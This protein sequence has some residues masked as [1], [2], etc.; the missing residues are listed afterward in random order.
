MKKILFSAVLIVIGQSATAQWTTSGTSIYNT[1]TGNVGI[2]TTTPVT[3]L[4]ISTAST[5]DG[6]RIYQTGTTA[7]AVGLF[8]NSLNAHN[9]ALFS[10]GSGNFEGAGHFGLFDY[11]AGGYRFFIYGLNGNMGIGTGSAIPTAKLQVVNSTTSSTGTFNTGVFEA[12]LYVDGV[13]T[14]LKATTTNQVGATQNLSRGVYG[15]AQ[16]PNL[17]GNFSSYNY[18]VHGSATGGHSNYGGYFEASTSAPSGS[19]VGIYAGG[20]TW[21]AFLSG[22]SYCSGGT[23][24]GSDRK[25]KSDIKPLTNALDKINQLKPSTYN[26][27]TDEYASM[28][29]PQGTQTGLIAQELELVF[30]ELVKEVKE[31]NHFDENGKVIATTPSFKSVNYTGLIPVLIGAIQEQ[32]QQINELKALLQATTANAISSNAVSLSDQNS[33]VLNQN[34]PNPFQESTLITYSIPQSFKKAQLI[35]ITGE[36]RVIKT[37]DIL[38]AGAGRLTV[39]ANDLSSGTYTYSLVI[40]GETIDSKRM[41]KQ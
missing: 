26:Y 32:Q 12:N 33:I 41:V 18:G 30:P 8:N 28:N 23:Y 39:F 38:E 36:G 14:A 19:S 37:V 27:K 6:L 20:A 31:F 34:T 10:T 5:N 29:L 3:K 7:A 35:F 21:S 9:Y 4:Q 15:I 16:T 17:S 1:N 40:D 25:L 13:P 24:Q 2:G 22:S 11:T